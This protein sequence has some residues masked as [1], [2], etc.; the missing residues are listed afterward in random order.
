MINTYFIA[1]TDKIDIDDFS[2]FIQTLPKHVI[3]YYGMTKSIFVNT[4]LNAN[5]ISEHIIG[6]YGGDIRHVVIKVTDTDI[7]GIVPKEHIEY[8]IRNSD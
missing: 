6:K 5:E 7:A 8:V 1:F 3:W 2:K 4:G